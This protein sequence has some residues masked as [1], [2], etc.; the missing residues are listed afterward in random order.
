M[1]RWLEAARQPSLP[2]TKPTEP[3]EPLSPIPE[4]GVLSV[5]SVVSGGGEPARRPGT[6]TDSGRVLTWTGR[7]VS[8]DEWRRLST[9][10]RHGPDGRHWNGQTRKWEAP[11]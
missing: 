6:L 10:D 11:E 2:A 5:K 3:T 7:V 9:W 1:T 4:H 8:L